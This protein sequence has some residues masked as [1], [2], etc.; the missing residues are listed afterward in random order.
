[1]LNPRAITEVT[2]PIGSD[3]VLRFSVPGSDGPIYQPPNP[4]AELATKPMIRNGDK[5]WMSARFMLPSNYPSSGLKWNQL[6]QIYGP[7]FAGSPP[8]EVKVGALSGPHRAYIGWQ[9][10]ANHG[11]DTPWSMPLVRNRWI[12]VLLHERFAAHGW[13][14]MS[15]N[16]RRV[17]F[18]AG[19]PRAITTQTVMQR[20]LF[21]IRQRWIRATTPPPT[22]R[23]SRTTALREVPT[24]LLLGPLQVGSDPIVGRRLRNRPRG[25]ACNS[26]PKGSRQPRFVQMIKEGPGVCFSGLSCRAIRPGRVPIANC[27]CGGATS[28]QVVG[29]ARTSPRTS[30]AVAASCVAQPLR[31]A[32]GRHPVFGCRHGRA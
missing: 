4:I 25:Q 8:W 11:W 14:E 9:R 16:G 1:M 3:S 19:E 2:D 6:L 18:F 5:I 23:I 20:Q 22:R 15:I 29:G 31:P 10:D 28:A 13:V 21:C 30:C 7:P 17:T 12:H 24:P 32:A 27:A 26:R